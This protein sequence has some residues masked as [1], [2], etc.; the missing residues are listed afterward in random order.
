MVQEFGLSGWYNEEEVSKRGG[1]CAP[2]KQAPHEG[3]LH[4][5]E[6]T[7]QT[8]NVQQFNDYFTEP[9]LEKMFLIKTV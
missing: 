9:C 5:M 2:W 4:I 8:T 6:T 1:M 3:R 7:I